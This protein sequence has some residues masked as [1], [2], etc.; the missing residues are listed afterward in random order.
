MKARATPARAYVQGRRAEA[1]AANG[2]RIVACAAELFL[3]SGQP[4]TLDAVAERAHVTVQTI[5]RRFGSKEGLFAASLAAGRDQVAAERGAITPGDVAG[6]IDNLLEHYDAWG[7][8][9]LRLLWLENSSAAAAAMVETGRRVHR[10]WVAAAFGPLL[11]GRSP[12]VRR[13]RLA[14]L[15]TVTD[16]YAWKL[17]HRDQKL[18][19]GQ[20]RLALLELCHSI[21][22]GGETTRPERPPRK[23]T[24]R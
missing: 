11:D 24:P 2:A 13:R 10:E 21:V 20:T 9:S 19:R 23:G 22:A 15:V 16:V 14:Q 17:L 8:R 3:E 1:A 4:P 18:S 12:A 5:L 6:A 7:D